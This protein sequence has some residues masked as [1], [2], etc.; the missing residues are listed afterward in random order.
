MNIN[1]SSFVLNKIVFMNKYL[2]GGH[3]GHPGHGGGHPGHGQGGQ[4]GLH[5]PHHP[6]ELVHHKP[7]KIIP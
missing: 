4:T 1:F 3:G 2:P 6:S 7:R 5:H